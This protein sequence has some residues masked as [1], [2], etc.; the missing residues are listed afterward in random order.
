MTDKR[1]HILVVAEQLFGSN[2]FDGTSVRDIAL[3][4]GVNLA[5]ISYYFGSKEKLLESLIEYRSKYTMGILEELSKDESL[6]PMGKIEKLVDFYVDR[7]I[8]NPQFHNIMHHQ[9]G[10]PRSEEIRERIISLK[11]NNYAQ[12]K[13]IFQEGQKKKVFRKVDVELTMGAIL[14]TISQFT[15]SRELSCRILNIDRTDETVYR[16]KISQRL[17]LH[18]KQMLRAHLDIRNEE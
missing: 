11:M 13:K 1:E 14:G 6:D 2:G 9:A 12:I 18:L 5:M 17:K 16:K 7:I 3:E 10:S 8:N 4:A 15:L